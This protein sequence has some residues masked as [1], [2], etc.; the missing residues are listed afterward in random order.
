VIHCLAHNFPNPIETTNQTIAI[1]NQQKNNMKIS[2]QSVVQALVVLVLVTLP[3]SIE[4]G[5]KR[6]PKGG[7]AVRSVRRILQEDEDI[8]ATKKGD[9]PKGRSIKGPTKRDCKFCKY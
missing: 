4:A 5:K 7:T 3:S 8:V 1:R 9:L 6:G 2:N